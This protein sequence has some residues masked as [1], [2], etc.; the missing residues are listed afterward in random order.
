MKVEHVQPVQSLTPHRGAGLRTA[1]SVT[2]PIVVLLAVV[3]GGV[4]GGSTDEVPHRSADAGVIAATAAPSGE[5]TSPRPVSAILAYDEVGFPPDALGLNVRS[6]GETLERLRAGKMRESV[7]A[8]A[9]WLTVSPPSRECRDEYDRGTGPTSLCPRDTILLDSPE[10]FLA[11]EDGIVSALRSP[12]AHLHPQ[13]MPGVRIGQLAGRQYRGLARALEPVPVVIVGRIGDPRLPECRP[14]RRHCGESVSL[15]RL[16]WIEGEW[17]ERHEAQ[18]TPSATSSNLTSDERRRRIDEAVR[19]AGTVLSEVLLPP[20]ALPGIDTRAAEE[21][22]DAVTGPVWY[23][24]VLIRVLGPGGNYPR[25][26]GWAVIDDATG[27]ILAAHPMIAAAVA[28]R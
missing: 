1:L 13:A 4:L 10:P 20:D 16:I 26:V 28:S 21:M 14:S 11:I 18:M 27:T 9:G 7:V 17:Q 12:G 25:G 22:G 23:V 15:E 6:V 2:V 8:V 3:A 19:G 24:R 5:R